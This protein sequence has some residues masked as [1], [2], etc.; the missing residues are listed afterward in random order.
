M[1]LFRLRWLRLGLGLVGLVWG[2]GRVAAQGGRARPGASAP[3]PTPAWLEDADTLCFDIPTPEEAVARG[4]KIICGGTNAGGPG[5]AGG[6][7]VWN[8][9]DRI[10]NLWDGVTVD[11]AKIRTKV[12]AAHARGLRVIGELMRM[13]HLDVL[14]LE[15]PEWQELT[16]PDAKPKGAE[17]LHKEPV[18]V[19][20]CW[21]GAWQNTNSLLAAH[22]SKLITDRSAWTRE[23]RSVKWAALLVSQSSRLLYGIPGR[24]SELKGGWI[25]SGVDAPDNTKLP[26]GGRRLPAHLES[27]IGCFRAPPLPCRRGRELMASGAPA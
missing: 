7:Y 16:S 9:K 27:A 4:G 17:W 23:A 1:M 18:P 21:K 6:P 3:L 5:Y 11:T 20:G 2:A 12:D 25:G 26:P 19:T 24:R 15:H 22:F 8:G 14:H 13:W 10:D